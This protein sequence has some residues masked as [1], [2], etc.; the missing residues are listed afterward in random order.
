[1]TKSSSAR[2]RPY[3]SAIH[4]PGY[5]YTPSRKSS[6]VPK[7]PM[8]VTGAPS[9]CKYFGRKRF[10]R[11]SP[12]A[13]RNIA[14]ETATMLRSSPSASTMRDRAEGTAAQ[15]MLPVWPR[16]ERPDGS[17]S[18]TSPRYFDQRHGVD[19]AVGEDKVAIPRD[20]GVAD[21]VAATR[22]GPALEFLRLRIEA[23]DGIRRGA[24]LAV[25]DDVV[26]RRDAV[27]L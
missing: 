9:I 8:A 7:N 26:D 27:G 15:R 4:P 20:R 23:H 11:F 18:A 17:L 13:S 2:R 12:S 5:W 3:R 10:Q 24:R 21:D 22:N 14:T 25:P 1:M 6:Q 16:E 19:Q